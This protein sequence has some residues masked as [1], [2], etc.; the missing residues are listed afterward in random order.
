MLLEKTLATLASLI[1][2]RFLLALGGM[3]VLGALCWLCEQVRTSATWKVH[4][5]STWVVRKGACP[6]CGSPL[7][8]TTVVYHR[9]PG[10]DRVC[11]ESPY[12]CL[13]CD[14]AKVAALQQHYRV[15]GVD[16]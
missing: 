15:D 14:E 1:T 9:L 16:A 13:N 2:L 5:A 11:P 3:L 12:L 8:G 10:L 7:F 4:M 6:C